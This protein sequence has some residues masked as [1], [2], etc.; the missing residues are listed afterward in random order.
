MRS[1]RISGLAA[2]TPSV[3]TSE[4]CGAVHRLRPLWRLNYSCRRAKLHDVHEPAA[5]Q[6]ALQ[7]ARTH[8]KRCPDHNVRSMVI[9]NGRKP[10]S[11]PRRHRA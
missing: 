10:F 9:L 8:L 11:D 4:D 1:V 5:V 7:A 3:Y 6:L 2:L